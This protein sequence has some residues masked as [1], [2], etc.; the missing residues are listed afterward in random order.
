MRMCMCM[1]MHMHMYYTCTAHALHMHVH[2]MCTHL[3]E[4]QDDVRARRVAHVHPHVRRLGDAQR[5]LLRCMG[6][7]A[8]WLQAEAT[9]GCRRG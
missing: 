2:R 4:L 3:R 6:V 5:E 9:S 8:G 7:Q 1:C